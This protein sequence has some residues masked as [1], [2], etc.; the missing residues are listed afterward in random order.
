MSTEKDDL[1]I[2][3]KYLICFTKE[4]DPGHSPDCYYEGIGI[5]RCID[6]IDNAPGS[7]FFELLE[8]ETQPSFGYFEQR[9]VVTEIKDV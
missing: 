4:T 1:R 5:L 3:R 6:P 7:L 9:N 2:G 8:V